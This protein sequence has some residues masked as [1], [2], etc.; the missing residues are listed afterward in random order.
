MIGIYKIREEYVNNDISTL[1][2]KYG[3]NKNKD[4]FSRMVRGK[5]Y[6]HLP[7]YD[8]SNKSWTNQ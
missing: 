7:I 1:F 5:T 4:V 8:K 6:N 3:K 2:T